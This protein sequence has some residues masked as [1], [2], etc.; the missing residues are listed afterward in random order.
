MDDPNLLIQVEATALGAV[1]DV[2]VYFSQATPAQA[3]V[4]DSFGVAEAVQFNKSHGFY[5]Q[6]FDLEL[7]TPTVGATIRYT[8]DGSTPTLTN[9]MPYEGPLLID[10]TQTVRAVAFKEGLQPSRPSTQSY[11]FIEDVLT[12]DRAAAVARGFPNSLERGDRCRLRRRPACRRT[13]W[14]RLVQ[15]RLCPDRP[16]GSQG[17]P[18]LVVGDGFR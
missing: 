14:Q 6:A 18:D 10:A 1:G 5:E 8:L 16:R 4:T 12:Q 13:E 2:P 9:S 15:W 3:N 17:H 7:S 11:L